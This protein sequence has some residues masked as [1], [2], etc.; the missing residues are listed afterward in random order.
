VHAEGRNP[1]AAVDPAC[2]CLGAEAVRLRTSGIEGRRPTVRRVRGDPPRFDVVA[3][4]AG[5][6]E[7]AA[8]AAEGELPVAPRAALA[9]RSGVIEFKPAQKPPR[10]LPHSDRLSQ[11]NERPT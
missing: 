4:V 6:A 9:V 2:L 1:R 5:A 11:L 7:A 8:V 3:A 10:S